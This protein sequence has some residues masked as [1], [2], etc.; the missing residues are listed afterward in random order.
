MHHG[1][2]VTDRNFH[3]RIHRSKDNW[4]GTAST[5]TS[6]PGASV[7]WALRHTIW[8]KASISRRFG[9]RRAG[10]LRKTFMMLRKIVFNV[11]NRRPCN[12][13]RQMFASMLRVCLW[14]VASSMRPTFSVSDKKRTGAR[15]GAL[16]LP[17][18]R[19][20]QRGLGQGVRGMAHILHG[21]ECPPSDGAFSDRPGAIVGRIV[22]RE[23]SNPVVMSITARPDSSSGF[24][25][26]TT[27]VAPYTAGLILPESSA[28]QVGS[29]ASLPPPPSMFPA[30]EHCAMLVGEDTHVLRD[31]GILATFAACFGSFC[32]NF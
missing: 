25:G 26:G 12:I 17:P 4:L 11:A 15:T 23:S 22:R 9:G 5:R 32:C 14:Y 19:G 20:S 18:G 29:A 24:H 8:M 31:A 2:Q 21:I 27:T 16:F 30:R 10:M 13:Q 7:G 6:D 1:I 28:G 3:E